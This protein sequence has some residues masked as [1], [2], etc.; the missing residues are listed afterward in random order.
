MKIN[1]H[2]L[3]FGLL[4]VSLFSCKKDCNETPQKEVKT[5]TLQPGS[6]DG[7]DCIVAYR[8]T[9]EGRSANTNHSGNPDIDMSAWTYYAE[10]W[11][12]GAN[13]TYLQFTGLSSLPENAVVKSAK[14]SLFGL[15]EGEFNASPQ[16]NS[17]Y[18]GSPYER[19]GANNAWIKEVTG[20]WEESTITWNSKPATID[21]NQVAIPASATRYDYSVELNVT[22]MV[23]HMV[24]NNS[25]HGFCLQ[26][27]TEE[28]YRCLSFCGSEATDQAR[29]PKLVVEYTEE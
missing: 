23:K 24:D 13:R 5:I 17:Y 22:A 29:H 18:P 25:N 20:A 2:Y 9:D 11:G 28:Y 1:V 19:F 12:P 6:K 7:Q 14:L 10:D 21:D 4:A 15:H 27:D 26:L 16:G 8:E 3:L